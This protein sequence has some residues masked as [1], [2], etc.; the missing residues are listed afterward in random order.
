MLVSRLVHLFCAEYLAYVISIL[1]GYSSALDA[2]SFVL[3]L[4]ITK[5]AKVAE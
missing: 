4:L 5:M 2:F 3:D 1:D